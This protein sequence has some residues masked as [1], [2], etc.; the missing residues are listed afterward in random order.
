MANG[1]RV[2][3]PAAAGQGIAGALIS[4]DGLDVHVLAWW[5][6]AAGQGPPSLLANE[7]PD[8]VILGLTRPVQHR[9]E[10]SGVVPAV[11]QAPRT[12]TGRLRAPQGSRRLVDQ[13]TGND[14]PYFDG[15]FLSEIS[16]LP[17]GYQL[18]KH[19][20]EPVNRAGLPAGSLVWCR[21]YGQGRLGE[22]VISQVLGSEAGGPGAALPTVGDMVVGSTMT[23]LRARSNAAGEIYTR[24]LTWNTGGFAFSASFAIGRNLFPGK[25]PRAGASLLGTHSDLLRIMR[26]MHHGGDAI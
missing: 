13:L 15:R 20:I 14:I 9:R 21:N 19:F 3:A 7:R 18:R 12:V 24:A 11:G 10:G 22:L 5:N 4:A 16:W 23:I 1:G 8:S 17:D 2:P 6:E 25:M 26:R